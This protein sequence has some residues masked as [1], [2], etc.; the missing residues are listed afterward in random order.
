MQH[1]GLGADVGD[2]DVVC[3]LCCSSSRKIKDPADG[4]SCT[5]YEFTASAVNILKC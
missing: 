3:S 4:S 2:V 5:W 1:R